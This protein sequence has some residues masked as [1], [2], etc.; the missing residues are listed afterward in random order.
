MTPN[1]KNVLGQL[2]ERD[3]YGLELVSGSDGQLKKNAIYVILGRME[4]KGLIE[5]R[6]EPAPVGSQGPPRRRYSSTDKGKKY[7]ADGLKE[8]ET[9]E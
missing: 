3:K 8:Q 5:G 9:A 7:L 4:T 2:N 1:E 6:Q